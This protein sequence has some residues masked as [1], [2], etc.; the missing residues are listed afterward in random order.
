[1]A[2]PDGRQ[3]TRAVIVVAVLLVAIPL[4]G[5]LG[6]ATVSAFVDSPVSGVLVLAGSVTA[7][8]VIGLGLYIVAEGRV[9]SFLARYTQE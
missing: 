9:P 5:F 6:A 3:F 2:F 1:M 4:G 7:I 8:A